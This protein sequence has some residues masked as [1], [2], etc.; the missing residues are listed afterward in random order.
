VRTY[1]PVTPAEH[2]CGRCGALFICRYKPKWC[3]QCRIALR[4]ERAEKRSAAQKVHPTAR[5]CR[6]CQKVFYAIGK[7]L[8]CSKQCGWKHRRSRSDGVLPLAERQALRRA[9]SKYAFNC[10]VCGKQAVARLSGWQRRQGHRFKHCSLACAAV[11]RAEAKQPQFSKVVCAACLICGSAFVSRSGRKVLTCGVQ[12]RTALVQRQAVE[13]AKNR[14]AKRCRHCG[15]AF[16]PLYPYG[17]GMHYCG[18]ACRDAGAEIAKRAAKRNTRRKYGNKWRSIARYY[19]VFY[20]PVNVMR[21]FDRDGWRCQICGIDTPAKLRGT[22]KPNAPE[23]D[24]R[25]P[26]SKNGPHSYN[27]TQCACRK[28]NGAKSNKMQL[29][30]LPMFSIR[31]GGGLS[32]KINFPQETASRA[33]SQHAKTKPRMTADASA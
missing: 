15:V 3:S 16:S 18:M 14:P 23:L 2:K 27:N 22:Y 32:E 9:A 31:C 19:G 17:R 1:K 26:I 8:F 29:G 6:G 33:F 20:E 30:Q 25:I 24:H 13:A 4:R 5:G 28:C 7:Q 11:T 10:A 12:C 21:V